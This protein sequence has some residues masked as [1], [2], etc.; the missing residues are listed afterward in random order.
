MV[1]S[2]TCLLLASVRYWR[3]TNARNIADWLARLDAFRA[4]RRGHVLD[5]WNEVAPLGNTDSEGLF[6]RRFRRRGATD[7]RVDIEAGP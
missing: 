6:D 3:C 4:F 2:A 5:G 7:H 1:G